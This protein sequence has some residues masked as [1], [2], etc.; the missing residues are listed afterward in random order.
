MPVAEL[1]RHL[2]ELEGEGE[3]QRVGVLPAALARRERLLQHPAG[4]EGVVPL[5]VQPCQQVRGVQHL[6][7]VVT[8]RRGSGF[9]GLREQLPGGAE[10]ARGAQGEG[11][12]L[13]GRQGGGMGHVAMLP[14][15]G[16]RTLPGHASAVCRCGRFGAA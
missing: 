14:S 9:D 10:V 3:H 1:L 2:S 13:G 6:G 16:R 12:V 7:M 11:S 5:P 4:G 15:E 8:V